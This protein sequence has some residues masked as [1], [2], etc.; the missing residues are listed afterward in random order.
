MTATGEDFTRDKA[1]AALEEI[2]RGFSTSKRA[3]IGPLTVQIDT[4]NPCN[5]KCACCWTYSPA[6]EPAHDQFLR[7]RLDYEVYKRLL[8]DL[9]NVGCKRLTFAGVGDPL[10]HPR[11]DDMIALAHS[12]GF[13]VIVTTNG[14]LLSKRRIDRWMDSGPSWISISMLGASERTWQ[15]MHP[16][17]D[18]EQYGRLVAG[19]RR[20]AM[21]KRELQRD[22][23]GV[24]I[25]HL[26]CRQSREDAEEAVKVA[27]ELD[28]NG[29]EFYPMDVFPEI[30]GMELCDDDIP[31]VQASLKRAATIAD[32]TGV[33]TNIEDLLRIYGSSPDKKT[34]R[35]PHDVPCF[36][37][38]VF[39]RVMTDGSVYPCCGSVGRMPPLGNVCE[40]SFA[41]IWYSHTYNE[42]R[43]KSKYWSSQEQ[44][45]F[46]E[47]IGCESCPDMYTNLKYRDSLGSLIPT[48]ISGD[49][50]PA[51]EKPDQ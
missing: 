18:P 28:A 41:D 6:V 11:I 50:G 46:R 17:D 5:L 7:Q 4:S 40:E 42:F 14:T 21:R 37:G 19:L 35:Q 30:K 29:V 34:Q 13:C 47:Q 27:A 1:S 24:T 16:A 48:S 39:A 32:R 38:W 33:T 3:F 25:T 2:A 23:P 51:K 22:T 12:L 15:A 26:L 43:Y 45:R 20:L 31:L 10:L 36:H 9:Y 49:S 44:A 8:K